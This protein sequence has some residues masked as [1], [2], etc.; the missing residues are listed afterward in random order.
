MIAFFQRYL[1]FALFIYFS[2]TNFDLF[3]FINQS[4]T[5]FIFHWSSLLT[6]VLLHVIAFRINQITILL[7]SISN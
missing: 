4:I 1:F 5:F 7:Y 2:E 3:P 6:L